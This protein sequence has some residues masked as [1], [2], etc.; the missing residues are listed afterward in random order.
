[1]FDKNILTFN[2]GWDAQGNPVESFTDVREI[3]RQVKAKGVSLS[4]EADEATEGPASFIAIDPDGNPL[5][6]GPARL[7]ILEDGWPMPDAKLPSDSGAHTH[8]GRN[9]ARMAGY[10]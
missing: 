4:S 9:Q 6:G 2:P 1:M 5:P 10:C 3:Q 7:T 8:T